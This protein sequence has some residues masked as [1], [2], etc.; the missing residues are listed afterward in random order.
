MGF[1][2]ACVLARVCSSLITW[3][4]S[5]LVEAIASDM[6]G[7]VF[8]EFVDCVMVAFEILNAKSIHVL[9]QVDEG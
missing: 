2:E 3:K 5:V 4:A 9:F 1:A 8:E 7:G 6:R